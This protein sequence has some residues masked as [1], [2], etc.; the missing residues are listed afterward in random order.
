M[1]LLI[2][3]TAT[4]NKAPDHQTPDPVSPTDTCSL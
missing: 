2:F 4:K 3:T 1:E